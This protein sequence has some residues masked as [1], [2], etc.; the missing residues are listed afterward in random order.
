MTERLASLHLE[1]G[2]SRDDL[3]DL[4]ARATPLARPSSRQ[5]A[6]ESE[7]DV[8]RAHLVRRCIY[9]EVR[10]RGGS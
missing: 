9:E 6:R 3:T 10:M 7:G 8:P 5:H 4:D 2:E 1:A